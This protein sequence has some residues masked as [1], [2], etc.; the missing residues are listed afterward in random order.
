[1]PLGRYVAA[2]SL[3]EQPARAADKRNETTRAVREPMRQRI[4]QSSSI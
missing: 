4:E 1:M 3:D 2:Y